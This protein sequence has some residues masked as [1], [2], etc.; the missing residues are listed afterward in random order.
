[1]LIS[2]WCRFCGYSDIRE[3][4]TSLVA[5]VTRQGEDRETTAV[6]RLLSPS[7]LLLHGPSGCGKTTLV[8]AVLSNSGINAI[9]IR[10][11]YFVLY[12]ANTSITH[13]THTGLDIEMSHL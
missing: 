5:S 1:M 4:V 8:N 6:K 13:T 10:T 12:L 3:Q 9:G 7:G 11:F 2:L